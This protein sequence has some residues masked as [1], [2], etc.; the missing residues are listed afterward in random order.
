MTAR[1]TP[2]SSLLTRLRHR[3]PGLGASLLNGA[4]AAA[5]GLG[6][7][8]VL[9]MA[10]WIVSP[11]PDSGPGGAL[12]I[13]AVLWLLAH[14]AELVRVDTL[15]GLAAPVGVTPLLLLALPVWLVHRAARDAAADGGDGTPPASG[16]TAWAGVVL[17]YLAVATCAAVY[18]GGGEPRPSWP[19]TVLCVPLLAMGAAA[20]GV[21]TACERQP[22]AADGL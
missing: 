3:T 11:Y 10:L 8:S 14:G 4:V 2:L 13:A 5:L 9:V 1:R 19:W 22:E 18:A 7:L 12:R 15:S 16:R 21:W 20:V 17:G 6:A